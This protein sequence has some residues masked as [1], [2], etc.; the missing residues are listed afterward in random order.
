MVTEELKQILMDRFCGWELVDFLQVTT[1]EV[2]DAFE[3]KIDDNLEDILDWVGLRH[4]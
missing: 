3:D 4:E 1:E 2:I